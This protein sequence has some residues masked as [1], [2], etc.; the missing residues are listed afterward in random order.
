MRLEM[1]NILLSA[2]VLSG[3]SVAFIQDEFLLR[4][5]LTEG[6]KDSYKV[7]TKVVQTMTPTDPGASALVGGESRFDVAMGM[8]MSTTIGKVADDKKSASFDLEF[9]NIV[10]DFGTMAGMV[11]QE[12]LPKAVNATGKINDLGRILEMKMPELPS[13]LV[14]GGGLAGPM[15]VELPDKPVRV[16][17]SWRM[18]MP[19]AKALGANDAKMEAKLLALE[20]YESVPAFVVEL[21]ASMPIDADL[22]DVSLATGTA[23]MKM[24]AKGS[25]VMKGKAYVQR[26]NGKTLRM[27]LTFDTMSH[28]KMPEMGLEFDTTGHGTSS[29]KIV[30]KK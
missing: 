20:D 28:V 5:V 10:Y 24:L 30:P 16:G 23:P 1:R 14:G 15:M 6:E 3:L 8:D 9:S 12:A 19:T 18:A 13:S 26:S 27:D 17:D 21:S 4:R 7:T 2:V 25:L 11:P 22:S 29:V